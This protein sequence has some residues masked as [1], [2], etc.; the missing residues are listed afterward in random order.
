MN[1]HAKQCGKRLNLTNVKITLNFA[2]LCA[3][4]TCWL[5][6]NQTFL[7]IRTRCTTVNITSPSAF[8]WWKRSYDADNRR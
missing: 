2:Y 1:L 8:C 6:Q 5:S 3:K 7:F 4:I